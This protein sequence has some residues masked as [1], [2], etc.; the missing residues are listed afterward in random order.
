MNSW[1][2]QDAKARLSELLGRCVKDGLQLVTRHGEEIA[3][4]VPIAEWR[5]VVSA[6]R[7]SLIALLLSDE[8]RGVLD[9]LPIRRLA[10]RRSVQLFQ[11]MLCT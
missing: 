3:V 11:I 2:V 9:I 10:Q 8:G 5:R 1:S 7:P 6:A 4:L